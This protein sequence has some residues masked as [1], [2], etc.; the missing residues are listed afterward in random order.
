MTG[1][2][3]Y[4][5]VGADVAVLFE[6]EK[7]ELLRG[8]LATKHAAALAANPRVSQVTGML[9]GVQYVGIVARY[10]EQIG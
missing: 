3:P 7:P 2:D 6:A 1:A 10:P 8:F 9:D 5:R 4:L